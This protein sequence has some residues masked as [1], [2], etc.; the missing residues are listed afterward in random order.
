MGAPL[1][2]NPIQLDIQDD[3]SIDHCRKA[4]EQLFGR[5]DILI[6]N[7]GKQEARD[8]D[9]YE[10][11]GRMSLTLALLKEPMELKSPSKV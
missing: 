3:V 5:L 8:Q 11:M 1:N 9:L 4:I 2:V 10:Y 6:N 7:A